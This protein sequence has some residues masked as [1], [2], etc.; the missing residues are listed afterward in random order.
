MKQEDIR[1]S[2]Q[3]EEM[4]TLMEDLANIRPEQLRQL[5]EDEA[6]LQLA[7]EI[8]Q[9]GRVMQEADNTLKIDPQKELAAFRGR[10]AQRRRRRIYL[11]GSCVVGIAATVLIVFLFSIPKVVPAVPHS[12][13]VYVADHSPQVITLQEDT[14]G[15]AIPLT[16][17]ARTLS[18]AQT[19]SVERHEIDY[20][21][22]P[23]TVTETRT[24]QIHYH[25]LSIPKGKTFK[26]V[27]SDG[28]EV[29]LNSDTRLTYPTHFRDGSRPVTLEGEA[30]F[31]VTKDA[32]RPFIVKSGN[33]QVRVLGTEFY[34]NGSSPSSVQV[35]LVE[36]KVQLCDT[37]STQSVDIIPG[38]QA[39]LEAN[40]R[41]AVKEVNTEPYQ[42]WAEGLF[43]FDD[44]KLVDMMKEVGRY[45]NV[46]VVFRNS[47]LMNLRM[48]FFAERQPDIHLFID[49]LDRMGRIHASIEDGVLVV[50]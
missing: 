36:G 9:M 37:L 10:Q 39:E 11:I 35:T 2:R 18:S 24:K 40:G 1:L 3:E 15:P 42:Y 14:D 26:V 17:A 41:F 33:V 6:C 13:Q 20:R 7:T 46:D 21:A 19:S 49:T 30:Y 28:T 48:H 4:L 47:D 44:V 25:R 32:S 5:E 16:D 29:Y 45:Y 23:A 12:L 27:L 34:V 31:K 43:Y 38:Q 8:A 22:V 50:E